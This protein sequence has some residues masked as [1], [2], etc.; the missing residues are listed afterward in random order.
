MTNFPAGRCFALPFVRSHGVC[1]LQPTLTRQ[2]QVTQVHKRSLILLDIVMPGGLGWD[3]LNAVK[4][5]P[6]TSHIKVVMLTGLVRTSPD[7]TARG[8]S[9]DGYLVKP[10]RIQ[11]VRD[12]V[13]HLLTTE[14]A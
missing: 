4:S 6:T 5:D 14:P 7:V 2:L 13:H 9:A 12:T 8:S 3:V 11:E 1:Y 10:V